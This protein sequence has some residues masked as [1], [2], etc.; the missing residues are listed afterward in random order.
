MEYSSF[1]NFLF[2]MHAIVSYVLELLS[3]H[4]YTHPL[5]ATVT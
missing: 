5:I 4:K 3:D 1:V 2:V